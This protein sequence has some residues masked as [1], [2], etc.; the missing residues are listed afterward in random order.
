MLNRLH[1]QYSS[2]FMRWKTCTA[3]ISVFARGRGR[4]CCYLG[5]LLLLLPLR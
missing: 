2:L 1:M 5:L 3:D 4:G